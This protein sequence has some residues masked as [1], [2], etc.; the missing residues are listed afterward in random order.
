LKGGTLIDILQLVDR[1]EELLDRGLK[2]PLSS[3]VMIDTEAFLNIVDQ[4][5]IS[6]PQEIKQAKEIQQE[7]DK[8]ISQAHEEARRIIAQGREDAAKLLDEHKL[9]K[10]A[11]AQAEALLKRTQQEAAQVRAGADSYAETKLRELSQQLLR[12]QSVV[13]NGV[14]MLQCRR[15]PETVDLDADLSASQAR[16]TPSQPT[17]EDPPP[18]KDAPTAGLRRDAGEG[19]NASRRPG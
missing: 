4:M 12:I 18:P 6:I 9:I 2:L 17:R 14:E 1:L 10:A 5:R 11:E 13:Q 16:S 8:Y 15:A 3:K 19:S 7:R